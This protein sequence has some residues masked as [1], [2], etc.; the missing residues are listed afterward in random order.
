VDRDIK[1][2]GRGCLTLPQRASVEPLYLRY[3][4]GG[5]N[6]MPIYMLAD[7]S[8]IFHGLGLLQSAHLGQL[9]VAFLK[10]VVK[11]ASDDLRAIGPSQLPVW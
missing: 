3:Q 5:L 9:S 10:S 6:L 2:L 4:K 1:G 7:F 11:N 8:Q